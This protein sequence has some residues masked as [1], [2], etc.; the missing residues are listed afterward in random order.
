MYLP[1]W[2]T[3]LSRRILLFLLGAL[4][5]TFLLHVP[6]GLTPALHSGGTPSFSAAQ[7]LGS[8]AGFLGQLAR[9][10]AGIL[11]RL[12][13]PG[14]RT[15]QP[16]GPL[17]AA[18]APRS[19]YLLGL[20]LLLGLG[21]GTLLGLATSRF[22]NWRLRSLGLAVTLVML[23]APD[24]LLAAGLRRVAIWGMENLS[25]RLLDPMSGGITWTDALFPALALGALPVALVARTA[26]VAFDE[27]Y[28]QLYIRTAVAKGLTAPQVIWRHALRNAWIRVADAGPLVVGS[29][30]TGLVIVEL[31]FHYPGI[32]RT[33]GLILER[34]FQPGPATTIALLL[35]AAALLIEWML[36][37]IRLS[38]D[39][40]L[41]GQEEGWSPAGLLG[42]L[43]RPGQ[44]TA[45][46]AA[47]ARPTPSPAWGWR[48]A[49]GELWA[50]LGRLAWFLRPSR[51]LLEL[52][53]NPTLLVG[54]FGIAALFYL[55]LF[56]GRLA[57]L[58]AVAFMPKFLVHEDSVYFPPYPPGLPGYPL[59]SD[60]QG[61]D[62]LARILVGARYTIFF[63]LAV[64]PVR[65]LLALPW[66]L[67]A[68]LRGGGWS[69]WSR[70]LSLVTAAV[71]MMLI[72]A[73]L[74]PLRRLLGG[75][76][77]SDSA[78]WLITAILA[79][80]GVPRLVESIRMQVE[81]VLVQPF[82][83]GAHA[84]GAQPGRILRRHI[85]PHL[86]P[87]LWV[88]AAADMAW[89]LLLLAQLGVFSI[90]IGGATRET[91]Y[92]ESSLI[93]IPRVPDWSSMLAKPYDVVY[94]A[95]WALWYPG[96]A[97]LLAI[98]SFN[99]TA[100]GLRRRLQSFAA[101]PALPDVE[102]RPD[103]RQV[104]VAPARRRLALEW[105][106]LALVLLLGGAGL[107]RA[108]RAASVEAM[109][110]LER[111]RAAITLSVETIFGTGHAQERFA[112][113]AEL[114]LTMTEYLTEAR[115]AQLSL[116]Q[117]QQ[118][119]GGRAN[120]FRPEGGPLVV[121]VNLP[122]GLRHVVR[123]HSHLFIQDRDSGL[124]YYFTGTVKPVHAGA[125]DPNRLILTGTAPS[126]GRYSI[127]LWSRASGDWAPDGAEARALLAAVPPHLQPTLIEPNQ[128][129][130][131]QGIA[132]VTENGTLK[133]CRPR[134]QECLDLAWPPLSSMIERNRDGG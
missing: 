7:W 33:L 116:A 86:A 77:L 84:V 60:L 96:L 105:T 131:R 38:L 123:E 10:D 44:S 65:F 5:I 71:P 53:R 32:G 59:G 97:F 113:I 93:P 128:V 76:P 68:G 1:S 88:T 104:M 3:G 82:L 54:L 21:A 118:D 110:P 81:A 19:L 133:L 111:T 124:V 101:T 89:T 102:V 17:L 61:R 98:V 106:A 37:M 26:A 23:S 49:L 13:P 91:A 92:D 119:L 52:R 2:L 115:R 62:M 72:P 130:L 100:E 114:E 126:T 28:L 63:T 22:G 125:P 24:V 112:A 9:G 47:P 121:E 43:L 132:D 35:M 95:P 20:A 73:A 69:A 8:G 57:D 45:W 48:E 94:R 51:M 87:Q 127:T 31:L 29:L 99:L 27:V 56:G 55:A 39:P 107:T 41:K 134:F 50:T 120:L 15:D 74:F 42:G 108:H 129:E 90:F 12:G 67:L 16:L 46:Q 34:S 4:L 30:V 70:T 14:Y 85:L 66:G 117:M 79:V 25:M 58:R 6:A 103:G 109:A 122:T 80:G 18:Q 40:R 64:T 36:T 11:R 75:D 78:F 83:E